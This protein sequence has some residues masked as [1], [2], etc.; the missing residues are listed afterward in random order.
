M[1]MVQDL[2]DWIQEKVDALFGYF[3]FYTENYSKWL[4]WGLILWIVSSML[5]LKVDVK[6]GK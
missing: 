3:G 1:D 2:L 5:K 6:T 4:V